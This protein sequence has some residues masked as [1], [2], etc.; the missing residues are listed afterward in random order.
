MV[1]P[2]GIFI[3]NLID[4]VL[5]GYATLLVCLAELLV[6]GYVYGESS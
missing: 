6:V 4:R 3:V 5:S 2:A 1:C